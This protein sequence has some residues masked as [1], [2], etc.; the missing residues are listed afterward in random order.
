MF[1]I[2]LIVGFLFAG[3]HQSL[4]RGDIELTGAEASVF[5]TMDQAM[6]QLQQ[7]DCCG[8]QPAAK[9]KSTHCKSSSECKAV[10]AT[11]LLVPF[12]DEDHPDWK[13]THNRNSIAERL[14]PRPPN[15]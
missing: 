13:L 15:S 9:T 12:T 10:I 3:A 7:P 4:A 11:A 2:L 8:E 1:R 6:A 14:E 5:V